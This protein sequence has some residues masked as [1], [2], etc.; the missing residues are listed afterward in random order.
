MTNTNRLPATVT[1]LEINGIFYTAQRLEPVTVANT[2]TTWSWWSPTRHNHADMFDSLP[3]FGGADA[4]L[5]ENDA[6]L[7]LFVCPEASDHSDVCSYVAYRLDWIIKTTDGREFDVSPVG[8][9]PAAF[10]KGALFGHPDDAT[11]W[12]EITLGC[13][14]GTLVI[15]VDDDKAAAGFI[16]AGT[17]MYDLEMASHLFFLLERVDG[18]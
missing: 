12:Q 1:S 2:A 11:E 7:Y 15:Y 3:K 17:N 6:T 13:Q 18:N 16:P 5:A 10:D 9:G 8:K 14:Q 4:F